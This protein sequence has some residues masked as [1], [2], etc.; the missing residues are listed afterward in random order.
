MPAKTSDQ[1]GDSVENPSK[2]RRLDTNQEFIHDS[3]IWM[4]DGNVI[5]TAANTV[6]EVTTLYGFR[7]HKSVL[8]KHSTVFET[9]FGLPQSSVPEYKDGVPVVMLPDPYTDVK[10]L[11]QM[12]Y[13]PTTIPLPSKDPTVWRNELDV[14]QG[15]L[16]LATKYE[17]TVLYGR[18]AEIFKTHWPSDLQE[19]CARQ[20][21]LDGLLATSPDILPDGALPDPIT[22]IELAYAANIPSVLPTC[23]YGLHQQ[24][25]LGNG[26]MATQLNNTASDFADFSSRFDVL[27]RLSASQ[28]SQVMRGREWLRIA[29]AHLTA[30][31][32]LK[33]YTCPSS[34]SFCVETRASLSRILRHSAD[35]S[36]AIYKVTSRDKR[37]PKGGDLEFHNVMKALNQYIWDE[38]PFF[39]G[40]EKRK[41]GQEYGYKRYLEDFQSL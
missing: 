11:L 20:E 41:E 22:A 18:L 3:Q 14:I 5:V 26:R 24:L 19:Y 25:T 31:V 21:A 10:G 9:M 30:E 34:C 39:F 27:D 29:T 15:P 13:D 4:K 2:K 35:S 17:L 33:Y 8:S 37:C 40:L 12:L 6:D 38:L 36:N 16:R 1:D 28:I 7:C 32:I 23:Y